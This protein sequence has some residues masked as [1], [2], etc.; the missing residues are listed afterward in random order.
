MKNEE[1]H[2]EICKY[3]LLGHTIK[4]TAAYFGIKTYQIVS[5]I[6]KENGIEVRSV[7]SYHKSKGINHEYFDV[8]DNEEKAYFIG[9]IAAD[10]YITPNGGKLAFGLN[11]KDVEILE[12]FCQLTK[13]Q[14][15]ISVSKV[16]DKRTKKY[17]DRCS[18]QVCCKELV[19]SLKKYGLDN[20]K[21]K[22]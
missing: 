3:Y 15:K 1:K 4:E 6:L 16:W 22:V 18:L 8:I 14:N 21:T 20:N 17:Y 9:F 13:C 12:K 7:G 11:V 2:S 5:K 19:L 10:G